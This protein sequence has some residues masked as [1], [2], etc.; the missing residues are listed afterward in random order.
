[1]LFIDRDGTLIVEPQDQQVDSLEKLLFMPGVFSALLSL[2]E[3]GYQFVMITNQDGLGTN[4]FPESAFN[5][6]Q[7]FMLNVFASQGITFDAIRICGHFEQDKCTCRKPEVGLVLDYLKSQVIDRQNSYVIG[8]RL[9]DLA[10]AENMGIRGLQL[11]SDENKTWQAI[12]NNILYKPRTAIFERKTKETDILIKIDLDNAQMQEINTGNGF[13]DH[14]LSQ[15]STHGNFGLRALV[16]GDYEVDDHHTVEDTALAIGQAIQQA[17]GDKRGIERYGFLL[18]M[19][20]ALAQVAL[21]I[22]GRP[23]FMFEGTFTRDKIGE[24]STECIPHFFRSFAQTLGAA[25]HIRIS[26]ENN[27]HMVE[28]IFK[29]VGRCLRQAICKNSQVL[30]STK[31]V[32]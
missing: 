21:D 10:L 2:K 12:V 13:F 19:D 23:S 17:L 1:M 24:L 7:N 3:A 30:P 29:G 26:G 4:S 5:E 31:G 22:C 9:T 15:L 18:P 16:K 8:D 6:T 14:M 27:H 20:E 32:L 25:L 11:G 28:A